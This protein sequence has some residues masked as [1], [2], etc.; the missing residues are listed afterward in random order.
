MKFDKNFILQYG[1]LYGLIISGYSLITYII[2]V[3]FMI[4][5]YSIGISLVIPFAITYYIGVKARSKNGGYIT[6]KEAFLE[7]FMVLAAGMFITVAFSFTLNTIIDPDLPNEIYDKTIEKTMTIM[8]DL[9]SDDEVMEKTYAEFE[10]G[11]EDMQN[12]F[13]PLG[14]VKSYFSSL[15]LAALAAALISLFVKKENPNPFSETE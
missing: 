8:E 13:T 9:G 6:W 12:A 2:G 15:L 10:K 1:L 3:D 5:W 14:L 7:L 4:S 11:R